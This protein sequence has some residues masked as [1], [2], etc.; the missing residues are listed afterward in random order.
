[1]EFRP[2]EEISLV[3]AM[4]FKPLNDPIFIDSQVVCRS[5]AALRQVGGEL[6]RPSPMKTLPAIEEMKDEDLHKLKRLLFLSRGSAMSYS[7][8][9]STIMFYLQN[10]SPL[11]WSSSPDLVCVGRD[12]LTAIQSAN[13]TDLITMGPLDLKSPSV[14]APQIVLDQEVY[15]LLQNVN[16]R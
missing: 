12:F 9:K 4:S 8:A 11:S 3:C 1:V 13:E 6:Y 14:I 10:L 16:F 15:K 7:S 5:F 2:L